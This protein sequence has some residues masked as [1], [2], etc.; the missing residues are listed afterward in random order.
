MRW[1]SAIIVL[2]ASGLDAVRAGDL[3]AGA[4][5]VEINPPKGTPLAGYYSPRGAQMVLYN[6]YS[7]AI[8]LEQGDTRVALVVCDLIS[9]PRFTVSEARRLIEKRTG[10]PGA[11][12]MLSA[13][14]THTGPALK[15]G[16][17]TDALVGA[18][19]DLGQRYT[20]NLPEL[21]AK[22][23]EEAKRK[24]TAI[25][26]SVA[27]GKEDGISFNRRFL[28]RDNTVSWNPRKLHP[29]I[30]RPAGPIDPDVGV[31]H[32]ETP[33]GK[34]LASY[35]NFA[36]HPDTT[37]GDAISAD[38][39]GVLSRLLAQSKG[40]D[41]V[42][43]FANGCCGNINHRDINW[44]DRQQ[45]PHEARRIGTALAGAVC[46]TYPRLRPLAGTELRTNSALVKLP[47][48]P[49]KAAEIEQSRQVIQKN[50]DGKVPFLELVKAYQVL[51]VAA[52]DGKPWEVEV[53]V[54]AI[55]NDVAIVSLPGEIFVELGLAIKKASP[56]AHTLLAELA[57]GSI[58]YIPDRPAY[59]QGNYEVVSA[60][61]AE[62]SGEMLVE[63][64]LRLLRELK[65]TQARP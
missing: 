62:G 57:N 25:R 17:S 46:K 64:A 40:T 52:R 22:S 3:R 29:D 50:R 8:V 18:D 7:K 54:V 11:H 55:G 19:K 16:S 23:V 31:L 13:T 59:P 58:G 5:A 42:T 39:P 28:M 49:I 24:L 15:R 1:F 48:A 20:E 45:G 35:V 26:P 36:L 33:D 56:F 51:D 38:Y 32:L 30:I 14:H 9:L 43:V 34:A 6:L 21:I 2:L 53:Q 47:L 61:C 27:I 60:R 41:M 10:I 44:A 12:V 37:G 4:A 63:T 65:Q